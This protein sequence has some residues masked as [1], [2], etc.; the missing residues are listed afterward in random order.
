MMAFDAHLKLSQNSN[1]A[2]HQ[3]K[4]RRLETTQT[5]NESHNLNQPKT[6]HQYASHLPQ[7]SRS[8]SPQLL[9]QQIYNLVTALFETWALLPDPLAQQ[10]LPELVVQL[11]IHLFLLLLLFVTPKPLHFQC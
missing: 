5:I 8:K 9:A 2:N 6:H 10:F 11:H 3:R 7:T 4:K 1:M